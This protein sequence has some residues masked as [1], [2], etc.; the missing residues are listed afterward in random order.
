MLRTFPEDPHDWMVGYLMKSATEA[1]RKPALVQ[2]LEHVR[3]VALK[4]K[5]AADAVAV[6]AQ[7]LEVE[8]K[9]LTDRIKHLER[10][11]DA[12]DGGAAGR[13]NGPDVITDDDVPMGHSKFS[14]VGGV[15][16]VA[17]AA[18]AERP[19]SSSRDAVPATLREPFS[20]RLVSRGK[21]QGGGG[22]R[23]TGTRGTG[24]GTA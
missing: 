7:E 20:S 18:A 10:S 16:V 15:T 1:G 5:A 9:K 17:T 12:L 3:D 2:H 22:G 6:R 19:A 11:L 23:W 8:N 4:D 13:A 24:C 14:W 21:G